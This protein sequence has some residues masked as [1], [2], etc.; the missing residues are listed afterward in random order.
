[1]PV[2]LLA[3]PMPLESAAVIFFALPRIDAHSLSP[4]LS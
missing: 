3:V 1:L 4:V 2:S